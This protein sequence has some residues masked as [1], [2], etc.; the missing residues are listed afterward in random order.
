MNVLWYSAVH[1]ASI[2]SFA[3]VIAMDGLTLVLFVGQIYLTNR[4]NLN[5]GQRENDVE[6]SMAD[7][8]GGGHG[9]QLQIGDGE[10]VD[11]E[12]NGCPQRQHNRRHLPSEPGGSGDNFA[13][14][15]LPY[16]RRPEPGDSGG[17]FVTRRD[18]YQRHTRQRQQTIHSI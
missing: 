17:H 6:R 4:R 10:A 5:S 11:E 12:D 8:N 7:G 1:D 3:L 16:H 15:G 14:G 13:S 9:G 18:T 2:A